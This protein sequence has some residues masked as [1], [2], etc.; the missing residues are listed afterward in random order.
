MFVCVSV[1][2]VRVCQCDFVQVCVTTC[3]SVCG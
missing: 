1:C 2:C 3:E